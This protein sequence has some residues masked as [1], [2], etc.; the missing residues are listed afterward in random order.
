MLNMI[1]DF[2]LITVFFITFK[3]Y[4]IY[5]ATVVII[6]GAGL[7]VV[8]TRL[9]HKRYDKKQLILFGIV[10]IFGGMTLYFHNPIF[11]KWK[12]TVVFWLMGGALLLSQFIGKQ[13]LIQRLMGHL[14]EGKHMVPLQIWKNLNLAWTIFFTLGGLNVFIAYYFSTDAWVNFKLY[15]IFK[16]FVILGHASRSI[17]RVIYLMKSIMTLISLLK[18]VCKQHFRLKRLMLS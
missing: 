5:I 3:M 15:R 14:F 4:D 16:F 11:I 13:T 17:F 9:L 10:V 8:L 6:I 2:V 12:P 7:Q 1:Y 18:S